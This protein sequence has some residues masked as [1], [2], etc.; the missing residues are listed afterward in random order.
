MPHLPMDR[1]EMAAYGWDELD[2][3]FISGDAYVDH[4]SFGAALLTRL[5][6]DAGYRVGLIA[7]PSLTDKT[8]LRVMGKPRLAVLVS[9]GVVDSMVNHYTAAKKPR[10]EDCYSPGGQSGKRPDRALIRYGQMVREQLGDIPLVIGGIEA[11]LRRFAHYDYW[12][13]QVRRSILQDSQ[14]DLLIYGMGEATLLELAALLARGVPIQKLNAL[15]GTA[16]LAKID[17]L[18]RQTAAFIEQHGS[19]TLNSRNRT[20]D[21][22]AKP[23][24]PEDGQHIMLP[25]YQESAADRLAYAVAFRYQYR[26]QDPGSGKTLIQR[27]G[28]RYLV[29]NPPRM[30]MTTGELDRIYRLPYM[31]TAHPRY[32]QAG[33]V[34]A[35]AEVSFS[36]NSH[37][38]CFGGCNFCAITYHQGRIV[39]SRSPQSILEEAKS[40]A[41]Q[42]G[43]K[44]YIHDV[45]GP[46]ANFYQ[47]A[48]S[49]QRQGSFCKNRSC[50]FPQPCPELKPDHGPYMDLLRQIRGIPGI[51][52]VFVRSGIRFDYLQLDQKHDFLR[53]LCRDHVSGQLK[54]APEHTCPGVLAAMGKPGPEYY[55]A[56]RQRYEEINK[57]L[58]LHQ[59]LVPYLMSGHPGCSLS[60][61]VDLAL[62]IRES[63]VMPEQV[64]DFY[65]TPGTVSTTM[66][67]TGFDPFTLQ[68][69]HVPTGEEKILQRALLQPG[70]PE[71]RFKVI[72]ALQLTGRME[73]IG[74]GPGKLLPPAKWRHKKTGQT[75]GSDCE[76][77]PN[78]EKAAK[79]LINDDKP[80]VK[81]SKQPVREEKPSRN[82]DEKMHRNNRR[83]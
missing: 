2:F 50:L 78:Q 3:L 13:G 68:P 72:K 48:C 58:G 65:P 9:S 22:L 31:R 59:Y 37:R 11:S 61:A 73:L 19:F 55:Q 23:V 30:P 20:P 14:A 15:R 10:S 46:T 52:K 56:F 64:Q 16:V 83:H 40:L 8:S 5:L 63:R 4:P 75:D 34:P 45:G 6:E 76:I 43:F 39:Q 29:Q 71:N 81:E 80:L 41:C 82:R 57:Q 70:K 28:E 42:Q 47:Q 49:R 54:V 66:Y 33:G 25:D 24:L 35:L 44:G 7:Q 38:G 17:Q 18:P 79:L 26:E 21:D 36:I 12:S 67:Y 1:N 27:H 53:A 69:V 62:E 60:D 32:D 51:K 77:L 74:Y